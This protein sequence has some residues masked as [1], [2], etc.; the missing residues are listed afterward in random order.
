MGRSRNQT[1]NSPYPPGWEPFLAAICAHLDDDTPRL[2]FADW[3]QENGDEVRA[4]FIRV[5][6]EQER[7]LQV[8]DAEQR[9]KAVARASE[10]QKQA[11]TRWTSTFPKWADS[12]LLFGRGFVSCFRTTA[13][14]WLKA[15]A[16]IRR[17]TPVS[18]LSL[19]H[20]AGLE[21][22][23]LPSP[24]VFGLKRL[25]L[26]HVE[27][28][29]ALALADSPALDTLVGLDL[30]VNRRCVLDPDAAASV[31]RSPRLANVRTLQLSSSPCGD[32]C[33]LA[34]AGNPHLRN[35]TDF[36]L[37]ATELHAGA[38]ERL[39]ASP[40]L[41]RVR[42][43]SVH[44]NRLGD[45]G[46]RRLVAS[47]LVD[48]DSLNLEFNGLTAESAR[49]LAAWPGL[50]SVRVLSLGDNPFGSEGVRALLASDN[51][52]NMSSLELPRNGIGRGERARIAALPEFQRINEAYFAEPD[53]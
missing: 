48:L 12:L 21:H 51:L 6:C 10:L 42:D 34:V 32:A 2:V 20:L 17:Q 22:Q 13:R 46:V 30:Y 41:S 49:M 26:Q 47:P 35:L 24:L 1:P 53:R 50:R 15:G 9:G 38:F 14:R 5:Q 19:T 16:R 4:E 28:D 7:N 43:L 29:G 40:A 39:L 45:D 11:G 23:L 36:G 37:V 27:T 18:M 52:T 31:F 8:W 25:F 3:L 33:A 44:W